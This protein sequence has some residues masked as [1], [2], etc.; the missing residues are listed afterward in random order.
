MEQ[1][2]YIIV[3]EDL[4]FNLLITLKKDDIDP[5]V[6]THKEICDY[7]KKLVEFASTKE[8]KIVLSL[9]RDQTYRFYN[10]NYGVIEDNEHGGIKILKNLSTDELIYD[11]RGYLPLDVLLLIL[12]KDFQKQVTQEFRYNHGIEDTPLKRMFINPYPHR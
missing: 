8:I 2:R 6:L 5:K 4:F 1:K 11:Y 7:G 10:D 3:I 9:S 12:D